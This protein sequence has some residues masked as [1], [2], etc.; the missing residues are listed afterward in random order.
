MPGQS[1]ANIQ[2]LGPQNCNVNGFGT[3][4][5]SICILGPLGLQSLLPLPQPAQRTRFSFLLLV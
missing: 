2:F 5:P 4:N 3:W 1:L